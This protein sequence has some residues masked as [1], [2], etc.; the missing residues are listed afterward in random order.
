MPG[1]F[2]A[3]LIYYEVSLTRG[4]SSPTAIYGRSLISFSQRSSMWPFAGAIGRKLVDQKSNNG[5]FLCRYQYDS[6]GGHL[7]G[8]SPA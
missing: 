6:R 1:L 4:S 7:H 3:F 2:Q 8:P 5:F